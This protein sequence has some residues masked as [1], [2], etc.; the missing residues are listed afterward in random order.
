M[1]NNYGYVGNFGTLG[2]YV[3]PQSFFREPMPDLYT[4]ST[5]DPSTPTVPNLTIK[6]SIKQQ[7]L[8]ILEKA[9]WLDDKAMILT[10][11]M[12]EEIKKL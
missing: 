11:E 2:Y 9:E 10:D 5:A 12:I 6:A 3:T 8:A 1:K 4:E 7:V